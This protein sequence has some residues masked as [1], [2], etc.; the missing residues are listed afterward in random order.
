MLR[1]AWS[2]DGRFLATGDQDA[3]VHFWVSATGADLKMFGYPRK[4]TQLAWDHTSRYLATGGGYRATVWDCSGRGPEG[5]RPLALDA[6]AEA[7]KVSAL[8]FQPGGALLASG[9]DDG[10]LILWRPPSPRPLAEVRFDAP[11]AQAAWS[12]DGARL[13]VGTDAGEVAAF[14]VG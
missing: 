7:S 13:A 4:V 2:P 8:A 9:A 10:R 3:T 12:P 5:T 14:R 6:H 1:L 11:V